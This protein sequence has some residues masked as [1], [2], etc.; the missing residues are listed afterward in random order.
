MSHVLDVLFV[1]CTLDFRKFQP[2]FMPQIYKS[3]CNLAVTSSTH[4]ETVRCVYGTI[5]Q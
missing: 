2:C 4:R 3:T 1:A 5:V